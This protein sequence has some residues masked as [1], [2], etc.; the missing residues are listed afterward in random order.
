MSAKGATATVFGF[1][2]GEYV[3]G[4]RRLGLTLDEA[5]ALADQLFAWSPPHVAATSEASIAIALDPD[6]L[7]ALSLVSMRCD[8]QIRAALDA[9]PPAA[10]AGT[11]LRFRRA[12][13]QLGG[14][15]E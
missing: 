2:R 11:V 12:R 9:L 14:R 7:A 4:F 1:E 5:L 13:L 15:A 6:V 3:D 10:R 8:R